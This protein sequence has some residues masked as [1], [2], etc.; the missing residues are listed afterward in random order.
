MRCSA[1]SET[2]MVDKC[3]NPA[4]P[5]SFRTLRDGRVFVKELD[6]DSHAGGNG[7]RRQLRYFWLCSTC[8]RTMTV[9]VENGQG[10]KIAP[11]PGPATAA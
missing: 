6:T 1:A 9:V 4:C 10:I 8:C 11:L 3:A 2:M 7:L 5:A